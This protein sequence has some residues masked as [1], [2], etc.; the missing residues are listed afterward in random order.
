M[1]LD[2]R[3]PRKRTASAALPT[4]SS[5]PGD[6]RDIRRIGRRVTH[7]RA[8]VAAAIWGPDLPVTSLPSKST[9]GRNTHAPAPAPAVQQPFNIYKALLRHPNLYFQFALRLPFPSIIDLYAID[10]EFHYRLNRYSVSL[11]HDYAKYHA[12]VAS[13]IFSWIL[14]PELCISD[15]M[16]RP[17]DGREWLARDVPGFRWIDMVLKRQKIVRGILTRLALEGHRVPSSC[18]ASVMKFWVLMQMKSTALRL[19][20]LRERSVWT[21]DD[22]LNFGLF[23]VKLDMRFAHAVL[24]NGVCELSHLLLTQKSLTLLYNVLVGK[25]VLEYENVDA[26]VVRT[27][28]AED[29]DTETH[30]WLDDEMDT[31][32]PEEWWGLQTLEGWHMDGARMESPVGLVVMEGLRRRLGVQ[33]HFLD[34]VTYGYVEQVEK[35]QWKNLPRPRF[36][37]RDKAVVVRT[38]GWPVSRIRKGLLGRFDGECGFVVEDE[39]WDDG[40]LMEG[41]IGELREGGLFDDEM[42]EG[43]MDDDGDSEDEMDEDDEESDDDEMDTG[44]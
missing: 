15:P 11:I 25:V 7:R 44:A 14:Y 1:D 27:Y 22:L 8:N 33:E 26:V 4:P 36:L 30:P 3:T 2:P 40:E 19:A 42:F 38:E 16:L 6:I 28:L 43:E 31:G 21:D 35:K 9:T 29:L 32:V 34:F 5:I 37:R 13:R 39:E 23:L 17:M 10:K 18:E 24:G 12:P 20:F 41:M